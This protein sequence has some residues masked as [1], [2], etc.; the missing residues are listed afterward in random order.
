MALKK[1]NLKTI[2]RKEGFDT[3][4]FLRNG[5]ALD[6]QKVSAVIKALV[7]TVNTLIDYNEVLMNQILLKP[8]NKITKKRG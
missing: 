4:E 3:F 1:L 5:G 7:D 6:E 2:N 8:K